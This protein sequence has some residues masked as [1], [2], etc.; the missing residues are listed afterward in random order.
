MILLYLVAIWFSGILLARFL[1]RTPAQW[2]LD[3]LLVLSLGAGLGIG[4][5]SSLYF[6]CLAAVGPNI[7]ILASVEAAVLIAAAV[8]T[9]LS[10]GSAEAPKIQNFGWASGPAVPTYLT[11]L[12]FAAA[13]LAAI[14]FVVHTVFKPHG[15]W[16]AWSI[17]NM[18]ARF[19]F[20]GGNS[21]AHAFSPRIGWSHPDYPLLIPGAVALLWTLARGESTMAP[22]GIAFLFTLATAALL[23]AALGILRGKM[24]AWLAGILVLGTV[25]FVEVGAMQY[26]D[27]PLSF[28]ILATLVLLSLQDRYPSDARFT[29]VAGFMAGFAAWTKNEG[30]L[31]VLAA[32]VARV[33]SL[34]RAGDAASIMRQ[35]VRLLI[36]L[37]APLA[38][39]GFFK[40]RYAPPNDLISKTPQQIFAHLVDP[41]RWI[42]TLVGFIKAS[43]LFGSFAIPVV[44]VL[45]FYWYLVR[46]QVEPQHRLAVATGVTALALMLA[47]DLA[48]Y[49]LFPAD[50]TWQ[51]NTSIDRIVL[52]LWPAALFVFFLAAK[53]PQLVS[54]LPIAKTKPAK[55]AVKSRRAAETR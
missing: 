6:V 14:I 41:G 3:N 23:I 11:I 5:A 17:W 32:V 50:V 49:I 46:F 38:M 22:I 2:S 53:S 21:W 52:Q 24:T 29:V 27:V 30:M 48:V 16:D 7:A 8:L 15:K 54:E 25:S 9:V 20:R 13:G 55:H 37:V 33:I 12:F 34:L 10:R 42:I 47:G 43:L 35:L 18:R 4:I 1:F 51:V 45:A 26:A 19:L 31:F 28:Y 44:L 36:G 40:L 39:V